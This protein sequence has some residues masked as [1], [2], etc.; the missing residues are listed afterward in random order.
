MSRHLFFGLFSQFMNPPLITVGIPFYKNEHNILEAIRSIFA[1]TYRN[2]EI[3]LAGDDSPDDTRDVLQSIDDPRVRV[4][5]PDA[6][7]V[8]L[9]AALNQ[10]IQ[11]ARGKYFAR[12]DAD[13]LSHPQRFEQQLA[14]LENRGDIDLVGTG[15]V[16]L[17]HRLK[18]VGKT[19]TPETHAD[20][21]KNK[22]LKIPIAHATVMA[23]TDWFCRWLYDERIVRCED[24]ELWARASSASIY[25]N[26]ATPLYLCNEFVSSS[27][28]KYNRAQRSLARVIWRYASREKGRLNAA[29]YSAMTLAKAV[30]FGIFILLGKKDYL[31]N[32]RYIDLS[33]DEIAAANT[34]IRTI[35]ETPIPLRHAQT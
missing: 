29:F 10:A 33:P 2:W 17:D 34:A 18:P 11:A 5:P 21:T 6:H 23:K 15:M 26:L 22:F 14:F 4:L 32:K 24:Y 31:L 35:S 8:G 3:V 12:M 20:I 13:D 7:N 1:Q 25:G 28:A 19:I 27:W 9:P 16:I 30:I